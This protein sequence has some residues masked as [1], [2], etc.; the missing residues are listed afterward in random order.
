MVSNTSLPTM[1]KLSCLCDLMEIYRSGR[2]IFCEFVFPLNLF[3]FLLKIDPN[4]GKNGNPGMINRGKVIDVIEFHTVNGSIFGSLFVRYL[5]DRH[6]ATMW[7]FF[8]CPVQMHT[9]TAQCLITIHQ[10]Q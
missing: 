5:I 4:V 3:F 7:A 6:H 1:D 8:C 9:S 10:Y 2:N